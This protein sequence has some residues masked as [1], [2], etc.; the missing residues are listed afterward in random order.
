MRQTKWV[1]RENKPPRPRWGQTDVEYEKETAADPPK[2]TA[3]LKPKFYFPVANARM[4]ESKILEELNYPMGGA[5]RSS[6]AYSSYS[7]Y[8]PCEKKRRGIRAKI[9]AKTAPPSLPIYRLLP[10]KRGEF[11]TPHFKFLCAIALD[12]QLIRVQLFPRKKWCAKLHLSAKWTQCSGRAS[13]RVSFSIW[14][15]R[16][17]QRC[18]ESTD[19][20]RTP[21]YS[22][23]SHESLH[24]RL[25]RSFFDLSKEADDKVRGVLVNCKE[26]HAATSNRK[27]SLIFCLETLV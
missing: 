25:L 23:V 16:R 3:D 10:A 13:Q 5:A 15:P 27:S 9:C 12:P 7:I 24:R 21:A 17:S 14:K 22:I 18:A 20:P 8:C 6:F 4:T 11:C 2:A 26:A 1:A 19:I